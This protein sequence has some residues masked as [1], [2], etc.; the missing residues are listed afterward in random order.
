ML[1]LAQA[2]CDEKG[3]QELT[4]TDRAETDR[5]HETK[6]ICAAISVNIKRHIISIWEKVPIKSEEDKYFLRFLDLCYQH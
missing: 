3:I 6:V 5:N 1:Y 4:E 2:S